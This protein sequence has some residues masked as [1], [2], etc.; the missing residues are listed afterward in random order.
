MNDDPIRNKYSSALRASIFVFVPIDNIFSSACAV[1]YEHSQGKPFA[2]FALFDRIENATR[3]RNGGMAGPA[4]CACR[5]D[6]TRMKGK[7][8]QAVPPMLRLILE[9]L[10]GGGLSHKGDTP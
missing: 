6:R 1:N 7:G 9:L 2:V 5:S 10:G 8:K 3:R 4:G